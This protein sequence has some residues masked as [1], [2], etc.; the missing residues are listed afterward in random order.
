MS[1]LA[2]QTLTAWNFHWAGDHIRAEKI[3]REVLAADTHNAN[4]WYLLATLSYRNGDIDGAIG[5]FERADSIEPD[6]ADLS[7]DFGVVLLAAGRFEEAVSFL[8]K[9]VGSHPDNPQICVNLGNALRDLGRFDEA[10]TFLQHAIDIQPDHVEAHWDRALAWLMMG[11]YERGWPEFEWRLRLPGFEA[12]PKV[13]VPR[14]DGSSLAGRT[15]LLLA[16][17]GAGDTLQMVRYA[18]VLKA[19]GARAVVGCRPTLAR[20]LARCTGVDEVVTQGSVLP[21]LDF[22][23]PMMSLPGLLRTTQATIPADV[24]YLQPAAELVQAWRDDL[25]THVGGAGRFRIG[26]AWHGRPQY[27]DDHFRSFP[28]EMFASLARLPNV[29]LVSL[30]KG[31]GSEH[32]AQASFPVVDFGSRLDDAAGPFMDTA[33]VIRNLD[34]VIAPNTGIAHLAGALGAKTWLP[35][36]TYP[37]WRWGLGCTDSPW[38][39]TIRLFR[40]EKLGQWGPVFD[41]M[42]ETLLGELSGTNDIE[43]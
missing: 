25:D 16:E 34:L 43:K 15:I 19:A 30:Q 17:Q 21:R 28:L 13:S 39:P 29:S 40:Q 37:D 5:L 1:T 26:I 24:P 42:A 9:A 20:L 36:S 27:R 10:L 7:S 38:Y 33:A 11:D 23:S 18:A 2:E 6:R 4:A 31:P 35:L 22:W 32:L 8:S 14:W 12:F 41:A 3:C